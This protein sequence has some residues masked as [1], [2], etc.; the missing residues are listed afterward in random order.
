MTDCVLDS[1][2]SVLDMDI[3]ILFAATSKTFWG[4]PSN[5]YQ[6]TDIEKQM[7]LDA[8]PNHVYSK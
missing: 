1:R 7:L 8:K 6:D 5:A 2:S 3:T 4:F